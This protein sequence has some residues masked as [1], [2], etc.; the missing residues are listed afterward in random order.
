MRYISLQYGR[1]VA[2]LCVVFFHFSGYHRV[3]QDYD[4]MY[5]LF[6]N[7]HLGVDFFFVLSGFVIMISHYN[8]IGKKTYLKS[9]YLFKR[10]VR[11]FPIYWIHLFILV[12]ARVGASLYFENSH[13][14]RNLTSTNV[15]KNILLMPVDEYLVGPAWSLTYELFFYFIF[16]FSF[17]L[18]KKVFF[19]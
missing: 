1:A 6:D 4:P 17:Y 14:V 2:A 9:S 5:G 15:I 16:Y 19:N 7:G 18:S 12:I 8:K 10:V 3:N 13:F 11:I